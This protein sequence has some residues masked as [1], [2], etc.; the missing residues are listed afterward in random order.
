VLGADEKE[1]GARAA[2][3]GAVLKLVRAAVGGPAWPFVPPFA[4][5]FEF[6]SVRSL[7][8]IDDE[9]FQIAS[10]AAVDGGGAAF[11]PAKTLAATHQLLRT[12]DITAPMQMY[13]DKRNDVALKALKQILTDYGL[14]ST[15][16]ECRFV[17][18]A[19]RWNRVCV[20]IEHCLKWRSGMDQDTNKWGVNDKV[21]LDFSLAGGGDK[22]TYAGVD[23]ES[24]ERVVES[25]LDTALSELETMSGWIY[26]AIDDPFHVI[27]R[28]SDSETLLL[29]KQGL[30]GAMLLCG[31]GENFQ[32]RF[33]TLAVLLKSI[34]AGHEDGWAARACVVYEF[35]NLG[36][37]FWQKTDEGHY[38]IKA[39]NPVLH[40]DLI[41]PMLEPDA[42]DD[43]EWSRIVRNAQVFVAFA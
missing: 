18:T 34:F 27:H 29:M 23:D 7:P 26:T 8:D 32:S 43:A 21:L 12:W 36:A 4:A 16:R 30:R 11:K 20:V 17:D 40:D 6:G 37:F 24:L 9:E 42:T 3:A 2:G 5:N 1:R 13:R 25:T 28:V 41:W 10:T 33:N 39:E 35:A 15:A 19:A 31:D 22:N 14:E 38:R